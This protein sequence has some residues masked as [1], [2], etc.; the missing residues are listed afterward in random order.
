MGSRDPPPQSR[1]THRRAELAAGEEV[2]ALR[3]RSARRCSLAHV[4]LGQD[5]ERAPA[6]GRV[7]VVPVRP[8]IAPMQALRCGQRHGRD[9]SRHV[10][11]HAHRGPAFGQRSKSHLGVRHQQ[12]AAANRRAV[13]G[14]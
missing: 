4:D 13:G 10:V 8:H 14:Q 5:A 12:Q 2:E 6:A 9:P 1:S 7:R 3:Q 11:E